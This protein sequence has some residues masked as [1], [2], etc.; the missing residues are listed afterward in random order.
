MSDFQTSGVAGALRPYMCSTPTK[1]VMPFKV[2][3]WVINSRPAAALAHL[4]VEFLG[5]GL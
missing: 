3:D 1:N 5:A 4:P 2:P